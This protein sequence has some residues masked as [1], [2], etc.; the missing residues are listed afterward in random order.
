MNEIIEF[1]RWLIESNSVVAPAIGILIAIAF[2]CGW[3][4]GLLVYQ[5]TNANS[6]WPS[7]INYNT[8]PKGRK[9]DTPVFDFSLLHKTPT[10]D[11]FKIVMFALAVMVFASLFLLSPLA[12]LLI[13]LIGIICVVLAYY[14][15][16]GEN[17]VNRKK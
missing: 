13:G 6:T 5:E 7:E 3:P 14:S 8:F 1:L 11:A 17:S 2:L 15:V 12:A 9:R 16:K 10:E 4:K